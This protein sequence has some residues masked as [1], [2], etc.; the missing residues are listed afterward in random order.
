MW[1]MMGV[2]AIVALLVFGELGAVLWAKGWFDAIP[3]MLMD[4]QHQVQNGL[5][6]A[7][8]QLRAGDGGATAV[9]L[10]LCLAYG[11]L[12]AAGPG[13]GKLVIGGYGVAR[14]IAARN[15]A[16]LALV[17]SLV[18]SLVAVVFV[19]AV[20]AL[21]GL[22]RQVVGDW[23]T[24]IMAPLGSAAI[25][26]LGLYLVMRGGRVFWAKARKTPSPVAIGHHH[27]HGPD[28]GCGHAHGPSME[29]V[30]NAPLLREKAALV[31]GISLRPC[32]GAIF[33]LILTWQL[34]IGWAGIAGALAM[35][36][37]TA[38]FTA[39]VAL[40]S[41]AAREGAFFTLGLGRIARLLPLAEVFL[42]AIIAAAAARAMFAALA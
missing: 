12:H 20:A 42:G 33:V 4:M 25:M 28:C 41:V 11:V 26:A 15:L 3:P 9:F 36:L 22:S 24:Q 37:G 17:S 23:A 35:G 10:G 16:I 27:D 5:A 34:G 40:L 14:R 19:Y 38:M 7:I 31:L 13:H 2:G 18:Q 1:R 29:Q 32:T 30:Q 39:A 8:R 21:L 6:G